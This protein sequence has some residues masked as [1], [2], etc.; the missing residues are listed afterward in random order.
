MRFADPI[1][2]EGSPPSLFS[3]REP[4]PLL[5]P[6]P[7]HGG[8]LL[9]Y[10]NITKIS[11]INVESVLI[12]SYLNSFLF[13]A[14]LTIYHVLL[15]YI[16]SIY[17][18]TQ[19]DANPPPKLS[20]NPIRAWRQVFTMPWS[21][22]L[23]HTGL[24]AYMFLRYIRLCSRATLTTAVWF[25]IILVPLYATGGGDETGWYKYSMKNIAVSN[26]L[27][28]S[29]RL[30]TPVLLMYL[31]TAYTVYLLTEEYSHYLELRMQYLSTTIP[32][33]SSTVI[34][35]HHYS[36]IVEN[37]PTRLRT[38]VA[39]R[40]YFQSLFPN[41]VHSASIIMNLPDLANAN[42][43]RDR[44]RRRL[45]K[46]LALHRSTRKNQQHVEGRP[47]CMCCGIESK[48]ICSCVPCGSMRVQS[49]QYYARDLREM[50]V[51]V[52]K[53][54]GEKLEIAR[55]GVEE[56]EGVLGRV[57][58]NVINRLGLKKGY[59][60]VDSTSFRGPDSPENAHNSIHP[61]ASPGLRSPLLA[62]PSPPVPDLVQPGGRDKD[63]SCLRRVAG[64]LFLDFLSAVYSY[65][66]RKFNTVV[67]DSILSRT[68]SSTGF[69]T[70]TSLQ[71]VTVCS[72]MSITHNKGLAIATAPEPN[73]IYW[74]NA[75]VSLEVR[76][77]KEQSASLLIMFG[78]LIWS[79]P[80]ATIQG[81]ATTSEISKIPGFG[82]L[83]DS[84]VICDE[85][86]APVGGCSAE[87]RQQ[88]EFYINLINGYLPVLALLGLIQ[89]LPFLFQAIAVFYESRKTKSDIQRSILRRF[90]YYQLANIYVSITAGSILE[91]LQDIIET[92]TSILFLL[93][94]S[95]PTVVGYFISLIITKILAGLPLVL[96][97]LGALL[98]LSFLKCFFKTSTLTARE[99][100]EVYRKQELLYGWEYPTHLLVI[101]IAFTYSCISPLILPVATVYFFLA[102]MVY[103]MQAL[104][105][106]TP[107]YES[108][109]ELFPSVC[110]RTLVGL[111]CG[112]V[113]LLGYL[114][115]RVGTSNWQ[116]I[117]LFPLPLITLYVMGKMKHQYD[118]P[119]ERLSLE[120][121][122]AIDGSNERN[123]RAENIIQDFDRFAY[124]QPLLDPKITWIGPE[125]FEIG[126]V[127]DVQVE[128]GEEDEEM[129]G[130][131]ANMDE[132]TS[133]DSRV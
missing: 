42:R 97:R 133:P 33:A 125:P 120:R 22:T 123:G 27:D 6:P 90:F 52:A 104:H 80:V 112:Q 17:T 114:F 63:K 25:F 121:A 18:S 119:S 76:T 10:E 77:A 108:G 45:E 56:E 98:R 85:D 88:R 86:D 11:D 15:I 30:W 19:S 101:V 29:L 60:S 64:K 46:A 48:P 109:G 31:Q 39:L 115:L 37:I 28:E 84:G 32:T 74:D 96:L 129:D 12:T 91:N 75:S 1:A 127:V 40:S 83:D 69:V 107:E 59:G 110:H 54:Q 93:S 113:T 61:A 103:K 111:S 67:V 13:L 68:M 7:H 49:V 126:Q 20:T 34:P 81:I 9:S 8:S 116:P 117:V 21:Q 2:M 44:V 128:E 72:G 100:S 57:K 50:N 70:F 82:W 3:P 26:D 132:D 65:T 102:L 43:R 89:L 131:N 87:Q 55:M 78:A 16:P 66:S 53:M 130:A 124:R 23:H 95:L 118:K 106:Y 62:P 73:D 51:L 24:D 4:N 5:P 14:L 38:D 47:R 79:V 41:K 94:D 35:Q 58:D 99:L 71:P 92:P 105:V 122:C 36:I